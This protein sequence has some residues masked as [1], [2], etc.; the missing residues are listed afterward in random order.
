MQPRNQIGNEGLLV[1]FPGPRTS[2]EDL[3]RIYRQHRTRLVQ[4]LRARLGVE[5]EDAAQTAFMRLYARRDSVCTNNI[6]AL[7]YVTARNLATD[8]LR[9]KARAASRTRGNADDMRDVVHDDAANAERLLSAKQDLTLVLR[10]LDEL[11]EKCRIS[12]IR[13]R[14]HEM[15]YREIAE[16]MGVTESMVRKYVIKATAYCAKRFEELEGWE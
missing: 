8:M 13:Y 9:T 14:F 1:P 3:E 12:F 2:A 15:D 4:Y 6:E 7:L 11:P 16:Q 10:I 5:A